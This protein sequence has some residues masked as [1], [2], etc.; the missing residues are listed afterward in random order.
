MELAGGRYGFDAD[1]STVIAA[2]PE[3][4]VLLA[5]RPVNLRPDGPCANTECHLAG[6]T[7]VGEYMRLTVKLAPHRAELIAEP[8]QHGEEVRFVTGGA[9]PAFG[10][11]DH[12]VLMN[13]STLAHKQSTQTLAAL[14][15]INF[16]LGRASRGW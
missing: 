12:A 10:L 1:G 4:G 11:A 8:Q 3:A 9:E 15:T 5:G 14:P 2:D 13:F 16:S 7:A 6:A